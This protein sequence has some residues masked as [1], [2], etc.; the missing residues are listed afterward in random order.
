[1]LLGLGPDLAAEELVEEVRVAV[2]W[3]AWSSRGRKRQLSVALPS[4][5]VL[6][7]QIYCENTHVISCASTEGC[8]DEV[9][10]K[11]IGL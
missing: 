10:N 9:T 3:R 4:S 7:L 8:L 5:S 2:D 11:R 6:V 1:M